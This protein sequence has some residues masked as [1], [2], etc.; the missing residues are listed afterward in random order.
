AAS[1]LVVVVYAAEKLHLAPSW[2]QIAAYIFLC[3]VGVLI[4]YSLMF[5]MSSISFWTVR[6]NGLVMAYYNLFSV[7][8]LP[9]T[10]LKG[11]YQTIW[12]LALPMLLVSN[13]P[14]KVLASKL[15]SPSDLCLLGLLGLICFLASQI[16][17]QAALKAY[18]SASS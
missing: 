1:G 4:H 16:V 13:V 14:V 7:A 15:V 12:V 11:S 6:S 17:W 18:K 2:W 3:L 9:D 10:V 5:L 8:R